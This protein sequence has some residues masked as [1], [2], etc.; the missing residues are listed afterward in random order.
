M[1]FSSFSTFSFFA[2][3][4]SSSTRTRTHVHKLSSTLSAATAVSFSTHSCYACICWSIFSRITSTICDFRRTTIVHYILNKYF[5]F[6]C[7]KKQIKFL[8]RL[9]IFTNPAWGRWSEEVFHVHDLRQH[10]Y[11]ESASLNVHP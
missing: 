4:A 10:P 9:F 7:C 11:P 6:I 3:L 1:R 5:N 8:F 2:H